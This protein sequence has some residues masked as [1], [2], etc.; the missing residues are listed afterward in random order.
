MEQLDSKFTKELE[1]QFMALDEF[2]EE[3][4]KKLREQRKINL[5]MMKKLSVLSKAQEELVKMFRE[6]TLESKKIIDTL[7]RI[8]TQEL[9]VMKKDI[10]TLQ[11]DY[12]NILNACQDHEC[13][14]DI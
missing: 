13:S 5:E 1:E 10:S 7:T 12:E 14:H 4:T 6:Q 2:S 11:E 3:T 9:V 8:I